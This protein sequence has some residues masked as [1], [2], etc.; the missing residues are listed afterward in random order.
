MKIRIGTRGSMLAMWQA[1]YIKSLLEKS[2]FDV[3]VE[4]NIIKTGGDIDLTSSLMV[5]GGQ[6][7]FT[8]AI[9]DALLEKKVDIAVHSLKDLPSLMDDRLILAA[10]PKRAAVEDVLVSKTGIE[11]RDLKKGAK[12]ATGSIRRR[13]QLLVLRPDLEL[14]DLRGNI[15]TRLSKME[16][17]GLDGIIM[18][19]AAIERLELTEL[20]YSAFSP[21][22]MVPGVSQGALGV[23]CRKDDLEVYKMLRSIN[24]EDVELLVSAE[25]AFLKRLDS[26]CQFPIGAYATYSANDKITLSAFVGDSNGKTVIKE[27]MS[28]TRDKS[29]QL[30][31]DL[32]EVF[33]AQGAAELL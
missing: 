29:E 16:S 18:A 14:C 7:I 13:S 28:A 8:K 19:K 23:Q 1:N 20:K 22:E 26:G 27:S 10:V 21:D 5:I 6:G 2:D 32:A 33:L 30:G 15:A 4:I 24:L 25:R 3:E 31:N 12:V 17:Q 9:E 11:W